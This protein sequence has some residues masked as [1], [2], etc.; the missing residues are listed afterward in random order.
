MAW[1]AWSGKLIT[2]GQSVNR[3]GERVGTPALRFMVA[4]MQV[5]ECGTS[6][7]GIARSVAEEILELELGP[8]LKAI[9]AQETMREPPP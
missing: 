9:L 1:L 5:A 2:V 8:E 4:V 3:R 6:G 7:I